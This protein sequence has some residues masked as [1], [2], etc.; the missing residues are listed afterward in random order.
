MTKREYI[1]RQIAKTNKKKY[2]NYVV[3]R[4][5]HRLNRDDVK[6]MTQQFVNRPEGH[7]LTDMYFPQWEEMIDHSFMSNEFK[8]QY[9]S[10][11][12]ERMERLY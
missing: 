9:K 3:T 4:I 6:F 11:L 10:I 2:E 7:A 8:K 5:F 12:S 1:I